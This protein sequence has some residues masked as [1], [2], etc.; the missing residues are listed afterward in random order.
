MRRMCCN[1][2]KLLATIICV[3][4]SFN[5][6]QGWPLPHSSPILVPDMSGDKEPCI[7]LSRSTMG[8]NNA[9]DSTGDAVVW[10]SLVGSFVDFY[11]LSRKG[12]NNQKK[13][14]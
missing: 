8:G 9:V 10:G 12:S 1:S 7:C 13:L 6:S 14:A 5:K 3:L 4:I 11:K 2:S